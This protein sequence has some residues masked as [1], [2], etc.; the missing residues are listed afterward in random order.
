MCFGC[1]KGILIAIEIMSIKYVQNMLV[2][3]YLLQLNTK[4][5]ESWSS[6]K[7]IENICVFH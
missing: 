7:K 3:N 6:K 4:P 5:E 1:F 2:Y